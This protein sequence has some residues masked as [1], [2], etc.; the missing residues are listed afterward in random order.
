MRLSTPGIVL[1]DFKLEEN[2]ILTVLT[3][4]QGVLTA[5]ANKANRPRNHLA[6]STELLCYSDFVLFNNRGNWIV[7]DA[8]AI[9]TFFKIRSDFEKLA[10]ASYFAQLFS[11]LAPQLEPA[12]EYIQ[13][14]LGSLHYLENGDKTAIQ[15]K[16]IAELR[17]LTLAGY[18]PD[19]LGCSFCGC[20]ETEEMYFSYRGNLVCKDCIG[21]QDRSNFVRISPSVLAAMRHIVYSEP[22]KIFAFTLAESSFKQLSQISENYLLY[23]LE[24]T[25]PT[26]EFYRS[27]LG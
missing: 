1:R 12:E 16:A 25:L 7:D 10:L 27:L 9:N 17:L 14:L 20:F 18:M 21:N 23:Q 8:D 11:E 2:R 3:K 15:L 26:L 24:K 22:R 4:E 13:L 19:L 5:F 6:S